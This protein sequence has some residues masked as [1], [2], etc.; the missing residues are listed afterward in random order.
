M[1]LPTLGTSQTSQVGILFFS[2][3]LCLHFVFCYVFL[4]QHAF[5][6]AIF[7]WWQMLRLFHGKFNGCYSQGQFTFLMDDRS[8]SSDSGLRSAL[9]RLS[10]TLIGCA[11]FAGDSCAWR[12]QLHV[13][14]HILKIL[15]W[16]HWQQ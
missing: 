6:V 7:A 14:A 1:L 9:I 3:F 10:Q 5:C 13:E 12:L 8:P 4:L 2:M 16:H 15:C 11:S